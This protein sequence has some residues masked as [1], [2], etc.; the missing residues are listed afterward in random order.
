MTNTYLYEHKEIQTCLNYFTLEE[1]VNYIDISKS[2][3]YNNSIVILIYSRDKKLLFNINFIKRNIE[4]Y[5]VL[6][7]HK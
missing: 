3:L 4:T 1:I 7:G 6:S 5:H 2:E